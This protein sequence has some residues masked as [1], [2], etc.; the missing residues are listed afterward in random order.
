[1]HAHSA[2]LD[3]ERT[4]VRAVKPG[5]TG[6]QLYDLAV[7]RAD[8]LGYGEWFMGAES[9]RI[10][11]VGHGVGLELDEL[12]VLAKGQSMPLVPGMVIALEPKAVIPDTGV[13]GIENTHRV[14]TDGIEP[15]TL[16]NGEIIEIG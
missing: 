9:P 2:M 12:P 10:T 13:A 8:S 11:F 6:G 4:L 7:H 5:M 14:T 3:I 1:M 16:L 15:L